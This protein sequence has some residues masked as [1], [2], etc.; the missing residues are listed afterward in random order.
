[1][2]NTRLEWYQDALPKVNQGFNYLGEDNGI[3]YV[4]NSHTGN[5]YEVSTSNGEVFQCSC[6]HS[7]YRSCCCKH[8][9]FI[10][11]MFNLYI[12]NLLKQPY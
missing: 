10:A 6:P 2:S 12:D 8:M 9:V 5:I 1:M 11:E 4:Y 7:F 3:Y